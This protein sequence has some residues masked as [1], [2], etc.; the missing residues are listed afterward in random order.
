[1]LLFISFQCFFSHFFN[2]PIVCTS[3]SVLQTIEGQLE[4]QR[5][6]REQRKEEIAREG[7]ERLRQLKIKEEEELEKQ[8]QKAIRNREMQVEIARENERFKE[9]K[10]RQIELDKLE[11]LKVVAYLKEKAVCCPFSFLWFFLL[12]CSR[13]FFFLVSALA[14]PVP[15]QKREEAVEAEKLRKRKA[16]ELE[17]ARLRALQEKTIDEQAIKDALMM[18]RAIEADER[19]WRKKSKV[20]RCSLPAPFL[21]SS[22]SLHLIFALPVYRKKPRRGSVPNLRRRRRA[23]CRCWRSSSCWKTRLTGTGMSSSALSLCRKR[24]SSARWR[25]KRLNAGQPE[26][27]A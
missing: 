5:L 17:T 27:S 19:A 9:T 13:L 10:Q 8:R 4:E 1:L 21:Q 20:L 26:T 7:E 12:S 25:W 2:Y 6:E 18:K 16:A 14:T 24:I 11:D 22:S 15:N 3:S 23:I